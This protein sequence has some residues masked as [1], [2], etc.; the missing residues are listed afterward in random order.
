[1]PTTSDPLVRIN[2]CA[3]S[4]QEASYFNTRMKRL[5]ENIQIRTDLCG[6][7][8]CWVFNKG[9]KGDRGYQYVRYEG[10]THRAH[11]V[12]FSI[13]VG[14]LKP[15]FVLDHLCRTRRC[16]NPNHLEQ[17]KNQVNI[18][19]GSGATARNNRKA[20]CKN[21]HPYN[22]I[23]SNGGR[24]CLECRALHRRNRWAR[25][26]AAGICPKCSTKLVSGKTTCARCL[27]N[28]LECERKLRVA[29]KNGS[30]P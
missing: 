10:K 19:R 26:V 4:N 16:I 13:L 24:I 21:G 27:K 9:V 5:P 15:G 14:G 29:R 17:V 7:T 6:K 1:M 25:K 20:I 28:Q 23:A 8:G 12:V 11:R 18:L 2:L 30:K 22:G 3:P